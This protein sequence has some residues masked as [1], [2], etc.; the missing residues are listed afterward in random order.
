[1]WRFDSSSGQ[2]HREVSIRQ[3]KDV[4][5]LGQL[6][7]S[8]PIGLAQIWYQPAVLAGCYQM[9]TR[10]SSSRE[11]LCAYP[12]LHYHLPH[13]PVAHAKQVDAV[14]RCTESAPV[15]IIAG[16]YPALWCRSCDILNANC[17]IVHYHGKL[18]PDVIIAV[19]LGTTCRH[20]QD[21]CIRINTVK[22][23]DF[24]TNGRCGSIGNDRRQG[25]SLVPI[26][27]YLSAL[28]LLNGRKVRTQILW[29]IKTSKI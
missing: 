24:A 19:C 14:L 4:S 11:N 22:W 9:F 23:S 21:A 18:I 13:R 15:Q 2:K 29:A 17:D 1:M 5:H 10:G 16:A 3:R 28:S 6:L 27:N 20:M 7:S 12:S 8:W 25:A 26:T